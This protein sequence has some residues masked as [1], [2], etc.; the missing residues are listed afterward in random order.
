MK[1]L[2]A[3]SLNM[4]RLPAIVKFTVAEKPSKCDLVAMES[5][6]GHHDTAALVGVITNR[7]TVE[8][9]V[10]ERFLLAQYIGP[11]LPEGTTTLPDG[12]RIEFIAGEV[13]P[14]IDKGNNEPE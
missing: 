7:V 1:L 10:G 14:A 9:A 5:C 4:L 12:A 13:L 2:N 3:F 8:L 6:I 11:R